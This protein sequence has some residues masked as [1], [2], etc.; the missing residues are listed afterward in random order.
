MPPAGETERYVTSM[1]LI[2]LLN[3]PK[4]QLPQLGEITTPITVSLTED[5][6]N[7][8][9]ETE[10]ILDDDFS[11][12]KIDLV[13]SIWKKA[14]ELVAAING[15]A[16]LELKSWLPISLINLM[17]VDSVGV[18]EWFPITAKLM[19]ME[20]KESN[21]ITV[22]KSFFKAALKDEGVA[23]LLRLKTK[24]NDWVNL[25][26]IYEVI[27]EDIGSRVIVARGWAKNSELKAFTSSSNNSRVSGDEARHGKIKYGVPKKT[28][29]HTEAIHLIDSI[30]RKW[31]SYKADS[32]GKDT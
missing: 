27:E 9:L 13:S 29:S 6:E 8:L 19:A 2:L 25:Y 17:Y 5:A 18:R 23:K 11:I 10:S 7:V 21:Q 28:I 20:D 26:R 32:I 4:T 31:L 30:T 16:V 1:K 22:T 14:R 12:E 3:C 24:G 15:A